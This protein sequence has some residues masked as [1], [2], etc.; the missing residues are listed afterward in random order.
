MALHY[1]VKDGSSYGIP[2]RALLV[3]G[4]DNLY[5]SGM[6]ITSDHKAHM[7]TRNTVSCMGQW[8]ASGTAVALRALND[9]NSR[10]LTYAK[11]RNALEKVGVYFEGYTFAQPHELPN[12]SKTFFFGSV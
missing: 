11:L 6:M 10:E 7:P 12:C 2:Y 9:Y 1:Q 3:K 4:I 8:Q 5:V